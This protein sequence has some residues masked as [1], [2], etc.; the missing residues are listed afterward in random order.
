MRISD[1][2]S[3]VCSSDLLVRMDAHRR[4]DI[5]FALRG[6]EHVVPLALAGRDVEHPLDPACSC[7]FEHGLLFFDQAFVIQMAMAIDE[8]QPAASSLR[9]SR[10]NTGVGGA[11]RK[12]EAASVVYQS[13]SSRSEERRVGKECVS[14]CRSR[15]SPYH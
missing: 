14:K 8:H 2:S 15:G 10:G 3:D 5:G 6:G 1:W 12:P 11:M 13:M 7:T 4:P 9:S